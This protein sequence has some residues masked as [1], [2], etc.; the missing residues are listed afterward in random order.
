MDYT[1][2][3]SRRKSIA[4]TVTAA[5]VTVKAPLLCTKAVIDAFVQAKAPW[6]EQQLAKQQEQAARLAEYSPL[7][8]GILLGGRRMMLREDPACKRPRL[9]GDI[10]TLPAYS[11]DGVIKWYRARAKELIPRRVQELSALCGL[12]VSGVGINA[13]R[14]RWGSCSAKGKLNFCWR[15]ILFSPELLDYVIIHELVHTR[16]MDHSPRFWAQVEQLM[17]DY[18][19]YK[20][21]LDR[22][23]R[24]PEFAFWV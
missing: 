8:E 16:H 5:G 21:Q 10:L 2:I 1:L 6:I 14:T 9:E 23:S 20:Q 17:P 11:R 3:R 22:L 19:A 18:R 24:D 4:I 12:P 15:L 7:E 13:A